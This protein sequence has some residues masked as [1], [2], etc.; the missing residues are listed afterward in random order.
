MQRPISKSSRLSGHRVSSGHFPLSQWCGPA[1]EVPAIIQALSPLIAIGAT[2]LLISAAEQSSARRRR[3]LWQ[4]QALVVACSAILMGM[5]IGG[6]SSEA[7]L[8]VPLNVALI[9]LAC[10]GAGLGLVAYLPRHFWQ[11]RSFQRLIVE[12]VAVSSA[13]LAIVGLST[14]WLSAHP[15]RT[16]P[17]TTFIPLALGLGM[18]YLAVVVGWSTRRRGGQME[19]WLCLA[20]FCL[21]MSNG[22]AVLASALPNAAR[23][24][25]L[26]ASG[27][28]LQYALLALAPHH[29]V[30]TP[31][32]TLAPTLAAMPLIERL[33]W[34]AVARALAVVAVA[35]V[36]LGATPIPGTLQWLLLVTIGREALAARDQRRVL[37]ALS[38]AKQQAHQANVDM[39]TT[40]DR[41]VLTAST[42]LAR[43]WSIAHLLD[44]SDPMIRMFWEQ[45]AHMERLIGPAAYLR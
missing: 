43:L 45:L 35:L 25:W 37:A 4:A 11:L 39:L 29:M 28:S 27:Y 32:A 23:W 15:L 9:L 19:V 41:I 26:A 40:L 30:R 22:V 44:K 14:S 38:A 18:L 5:A 10:L 36:A 8:V 31:S 20:L 7:L 34:T 33:L 3:R 1:T 6:Y 17:V 2:A 42:P 24:H 12:S 13:I 16:L 21:A